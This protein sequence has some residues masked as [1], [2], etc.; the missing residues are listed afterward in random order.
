MV[1][2]LNVTSPATV[3]TLPA[4][5]MPPVAVS[6]S[7]LPA[8]LIVMSEPA[9]IARGPPVT[10]ASGLFCVSAVVTVM[11]PVFAADPTVSRPV[12]VI[13]SSSASVNPSFPPVL[14]PTSIACAFVEVCNV[15]GALPPAIVPPTRF[16]S[17]AVTTMALP[18]PLFVTAP[19]A[20]LSNTPVPALIV[21][22]PGPVTVDVLVTPTP[23]SATVPVPPAVTTAPIVSRPVAVNEIVPFAAAVVVIAPLVLIAPV[24]F[25]VTF[26]PAAVPFCAIPVTFNVP[27]VL[28]KLTAPLVALV[29]LKLPAVFACVS[30]WPPVELVV[31]RPLVPKVPPA[32]SVIAAPELAVIAPDALLTAAFKVIAFAPVVVRPTVPLPPAVTALLIVSVPVVACRAILPFAAVVIPAVEVVRLPVL[33]TVTLPVFCVMPVIVSVPVVLT[34]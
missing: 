3:V 6:A 2:E 10:S 29:A 25:T 22:P 12:V 27:A 1:F 21:M 7:E 16:I 30:V 5:L 4:V 8:P 9:L 18:L 34:S 11:P 14:V 17:S 28:I 20:L 13:V 31:N 32:F 15:T 19:V 24:L 26:E 23:A 33:V